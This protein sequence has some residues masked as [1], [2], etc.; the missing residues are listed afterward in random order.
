M[1]SSRCSCRRTGSAWRLQ[2]L[3]P[4]P[5]KATARGVT[6]GAPG[7]RLRGA[8]RR[9]ALLAAS[10]C[11]RQVSL[12]NWAESWMAACHVCCS[13]LPAAAPVLVASCAHGVT[14]TAGR[15]DERRGS[16]AAAV[17]RSDEHNRFSDWAAAARAG[18]AQCALRAARARARG[19]RY[20][21]L[22]K[23]RK[24]RQQASTALAHGAA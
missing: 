11:R 5:P 18:L 16:A 6:G 15:C 10:A 1:L 23:R 9:G 24:P 22:E 19:T 21:N 2:P 12:L 20:S 13:Q 8:R 4:T 14:I 7:N 3:L 17:C